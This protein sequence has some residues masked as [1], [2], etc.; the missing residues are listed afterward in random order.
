MIVAAAGFKEQDLDV[1]ILGQPRCQHGT[2]GTGTDND[3][4]EPNDALP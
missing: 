1:R 3:V 4:V 2:S